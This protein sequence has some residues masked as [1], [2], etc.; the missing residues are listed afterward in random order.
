MT[1]IQGAPLMKKIFSR[2]LRNKLKDIT[3]KCMRKHFHNAW[4]TIFCKIAVHIAKGGLRKTLLCRTF[5]ATE[6]RRRTSEAWFRVCREPKTHSD[7]TTVTSATETLRCIQKFIIDAY[8]Q[9]Y[10]KAILHFVITGKSLYPCSLYRSLSVNV[11]YT[12][13][14]INKH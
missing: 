11:L 1:I 12:R 5:L 8:L 13:T 7:L 4:C 10:D 2:I 9:R 3:R 6:L 14:S